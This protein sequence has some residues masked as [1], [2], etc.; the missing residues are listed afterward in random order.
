M[1]NLKNRYIFF[2]VKIPK[3][4]KIFNFGINLYNILFQNI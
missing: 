1:K 3:I 4:N 2:L